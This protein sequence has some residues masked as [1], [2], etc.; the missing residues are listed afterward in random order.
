MIHRVHSPTVYAL[1]GFT[2]REQ[3]MEKESEESSGSGWL[4]YTFKASWGL[5]SFTP[6]LRNT[7]GS[8]LPISL[9]LAPSALALLPLQIRPCLNVQHKG[10][11]GHTWHLR[12]H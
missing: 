12:L 7:A 4:D 8:C 10:I 9:F 2:E 1:T 6:G 3:E 5:S 11:A